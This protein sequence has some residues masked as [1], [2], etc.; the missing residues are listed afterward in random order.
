MLR[1]AVHNDDGPARRWPLVNAYLLAAGDV[2]VPGEVAFADGHIV[3]HPKATQAVALCLQHDAGPMGRL[4]LQTCLLPQREQPYALAVELARHRIK[5]FLAKSEEWQMFDLAA[6]H[7]ATEN[8]EEARRLF[9]A[10]LHARDPAAANRAAGGALVAG[11]EASERLAMAHA[12]VLLHWRFGTRPASSRTLGVRVNPVHDSPALRAT[13][14]RDFDLLAIPL[15]WSEIEVEEGRYDWDPIDR[16]VAWAAKEQVPVMLGPLLDFSRR[17]LP[18]WMYV[19]QHDFNTCRD[20]V[21]EQVERVVNRY[22]SSVGLW[23]IASALNVNDNFQFTVEQMLDLA[24]MCNLIA[25]QARKGARTMI[26]LARPFGEHCAGNR[27]SVPPLTF[28]D[29]MIQEGIRVDC[30]GLQLLFGQHE[31]GR[32][33]RDIMQISDLI[34]R[35]LVLEMPVV[36]SAF[37]VPSAPVDDQGGWWRSAWSA[38]AQSRWMSRVF[39]VAMS[40]PFVETM[41]WT[42]LCDGAGAGLPGGGLLSESGQPKPALERLVSTRRRLKK[43]LGPLPAGRQAS[44]MPAND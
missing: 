3:C 41:I 13:V 44:P 19:W 17:S 31:A 21:Y 33:S 16:W 36:I 26:E 7:P 27:K 32:A 25:R 28:M 1:F 43:P 2:P 4:M 37:G 5:T 11:I 30:V 24:R 10:A 35:F 23:N 8:W 15:A 6:G 39:H 40:K 42:D 9:A 38:A 14:K 12:E 29:R 34:D 18:K 20:M 22:R